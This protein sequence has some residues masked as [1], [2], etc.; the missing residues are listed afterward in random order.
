MESLNESELGNNPH[1]A[2]FLAGLA[3]EFKEDIV[4]GAAGAPPVNGQTRA[5]MELEQMKSDPDKARLLN[6]PAHSLNE[7]EQ[8]TQKHL[9]AQR[10]NLFKL[11]YPD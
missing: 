5:K 1:F 6:S 3:G 4:G 9:L 10:S 8:I 11:A 7:G 2:K